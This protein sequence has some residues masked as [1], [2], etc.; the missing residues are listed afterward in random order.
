MPIYTHRSP[1][2]VPAADL[3]AW[4]ARPGALQRLLPPWDATE[5]VEQVGGVAD[6]RVTLSI[7]IG[8]VRVRWVA[9]HRDNVEGRQ[10]VDAQVEGPFGHWVH[11]H[12]FEDHGAGSEL[13]DEVDWGM[14]P[15]AWFDGMSAG[16][17]E[18]I[19]RRMFTFRH[20][21]TRA[22]L[23]RHARSS[24]RPL[25]VAIS[26]ARGLVGNELIPFLT[27]GGHT[28]LRL[29]RGRP[30]P[31]DV[32]WDPGQGRMD[33]AAL[34]GIDAFLHLSGETISQRWTEA[35]KVEM[36]RSRVETTDLVARSLAGMARPPR[37]LIVASAIGYY[38]DRGDEA[39]TEASPAGVG[40]LPDLCTA[41]E[42]AAD[43]AR[44]AGIQVVHPRIGVV[45]S[46]RGGALGQLLTP[47]SM[48][49]GGPVG[50]GRQYMS[51][52]AM[53]DLLGVLLHLI[54]SD[55]SGP[56]NTTAPNPATSADF[57]QTLGT[58]L[59]R[60]AVIPLPAFAVKLMFGEMGERL[61]LEGAR[62]LPE[63]LL[64]DGFQFGHP[65]LA[66]ALRFELGR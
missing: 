40:F 32:E 23:E 14:K 41:W 52:I 11:T 17:V 36:R 7:P 6:G 44:K 60:P 30:G 29:V 26:G 54:T 9:Q 47:Y 38:G 16:K 31:G 18:S 42:A 13:V 28:V 39:L 62:V 24:R 2:P 37:R 49:A 53:D 61:L 59:R 63:A 55:I 1:M 34:E 58:V 35:A 43:P 51:W 66:A 46:A 20:A 25:K 8:P 19:L 45:L 57:A 64:S 48:G 33:T 50:S 5:V 4:H 22:D 12:R 21:R 56:V 3:Y 65:D 27:T 10:F 15:G